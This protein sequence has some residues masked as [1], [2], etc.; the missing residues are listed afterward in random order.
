MSKEPPQSLQVLVVDD[1]RIVGMLH[2]MVAIR[3]GYS[4]SPLVCEKGS[5]ALRHLLETPAGVRPWLV[6]LDLHMPE[7]TGWEVLDAL[8]RHRLPTP[9]FVVIVSSSVD[10][11]DL[12]R[13]K[14]YPIVLDFVSKPLTTKRLGE[15]R[16][17]PALSPYFLA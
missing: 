8:T 9:T 7:M 2:R 16:T 15:L 13:A 10:P 17:H 1:D 4:S 11:S 5:E 12:A 6:F 14:Q 3:A